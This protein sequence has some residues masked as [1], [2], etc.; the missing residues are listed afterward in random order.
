MGAPSGEGCYRTPAN[1]AATVPMPRATHDA[2]H[3]TTTPPHTTINRPAITHPHVDG[4]KNWGCG[5]HPQTIIG[6][7]ADFTL[8]GFGQSNRVA[9]VATDLTV[10]HVSVLAPWPLRLYSARMPRTMDI[11][12]ALSAM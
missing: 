9:P 12:V 10:F 5:Q 6:R 2:N 3:H 8:A 11:P 7:Y 4:Q 1:D